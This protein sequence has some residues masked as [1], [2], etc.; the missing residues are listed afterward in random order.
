MIE[1]IKSLLKL[2]INTTVEKGSELV[3][4]G[5][6]EKASLQSPPKWRKQYIENHLSDTAFEDEV[7]R[8]TNNGIYVMPRLVEESPYK[9][10]APQQ[11]ETFLNDF[12]IGKLFR[13]SHVGDRVFCILA[14][15]GMGK[16]T[17]MVNLFC[18]YINHY[19]KRHCP[20][21]FG[22][23]RSPTRKSLRRLMRLRTRNIASCC[24]MPSMKALRPKT[25]IPTPISSRSW[26]PPMLNSPAS[27]QPAAHSSS[28]KTRVSLTRPMSDAAAIS[29][30]A[31]SAI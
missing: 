4:K 10:N 22:C 12:F 27:S 9:T 3:A 19:R 23:S 29:S 30:N 15:T 28:A 24:W 17:A 5:L 25:M 11:T 6:H 20:T 18:D 16:T 14:D 1:F 26:R 21:R 2:A 7:A 31:R 13:K 8:R